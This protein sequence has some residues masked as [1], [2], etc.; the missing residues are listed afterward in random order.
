MF[1]IL[2]SLILPLLVIGLSGLKGSSG[3]LGG[4]CGYFSFDGLS[5]DGVGLLLEE[6]V[7]F[8]NC[9]FFSDGRDGNCLCILCLILS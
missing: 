9:G 5:C 6:G 1:V 4:N 3:N 7:G 8:G 2:R